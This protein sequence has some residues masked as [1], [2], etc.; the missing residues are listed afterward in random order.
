MPRR[1]APAVRESRASLGMSG[2]EEQSIRTIHAVLDAGANLID[3]ADSY[4]F[5]DRGRRLSGAPELTHDDVAQP[6]KGEGDEERPEVEGV[7]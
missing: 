3:T 4:S 6:A 1:A 7:A 2:D 5:D